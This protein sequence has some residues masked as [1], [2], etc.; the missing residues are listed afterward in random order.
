M[1]IKFKIKLY[2]INFILLLLCLYIYEENKIH[3]Q[4]KEVKVSVF[5]PIYNK[6]TYLQR[7]IGTIQNQSLENIEIVAVND[8]S[9]DNTLISLKKMAKKDLRIKIVNNDRNHGLLYSRAMGI[10]NSTGEYLMNLDPDDRLE[11]SDNLE[12]LYNTA[13]SNN[14]D[15]VRYLIKRIP[16]NKGQ[17]KYINYFNKYQFKI[18]DYL[19]TNKFVKKEIFLKVLNEFKKKIYY[20][21]WNYHEDNIWSALLYRATKLK[22]DINKY[23]YVYK[24]NNQSLIINIMENKR[25]FEFKN[26]VYLTQTYQDFN[27]KSS[28][29]FMFNNIIYF[30]NYIK[31]KDI[32]LK[33]RII[34]IAM[35]ILKSFTNNINLLKNIN[36]NINKI[37][38]NKIIMFYKLERDFFDLYLIYLTIFNYIKIKYNKIIISININNKASFKNIHKYIF[39][40]DILIGFDG[41]FYDCNNSEIVELFSK[42][43][44]ILFSHFVDLN[45]Y[46]KDAFQK[47]NSNLTA[48]AFSYNS[49]QI[50]SQITKKE[51]LYY[52]PNFITDLANSFNYNTSLKNNKVLIYFNETIKMDKKA[53]IKIVS[54]YYKNIKIISSKNDFYNKSNSIKNYRLVLTNS[55]YLLKLSAINFISCILLKANSYEDNNYNLINKLNYIKY[56]Y[57]LEQLEKT[58]LQLTMNLKKN[59]IT[60]L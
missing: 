21:K 52:V 56:I 11:G 14:S 50:L 48:Y 53:I 30:C 38:N 1:K 17:I 24:M 22:K 47:Y 23:V 58:I 49:Y 12:V 44:I 3:P 15:L 60:N 4:K 41:F 18:F 7:S 45:K 39:P 2:F 16:F 19:M 26:R 55:P 25:T 31:I 54:K 13:K 37:S 8:Y 6:C 36:N 5:L 42:N 9:T 35:K 20:N 43:K 33:N 32:E 29:V 10:L 27:F 57:D 59:N 34:H 28:S 40:N 51:N 46:N